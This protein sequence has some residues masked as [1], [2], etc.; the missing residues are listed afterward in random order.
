MGSKQILLNY[1]KPAA[2]A[3]NYRPAVHAFANAIIKYYTGTDGIFGQQ[4]LIT[5]RNRSKGQSH[6]YWIGTDGEGLSQVSKGSGINIMP[7]VGPGGTPL[8]VG[9]GNG[10]PSL[11]AGGSVVVPDDAISRPDYCPGNGRVAVSLATDENPEI[12]T[13]NA[14]GSGRTRLTSNSYIDTSPSWS[15]DCSKIA[16][17]SNRGGGPQIYVMS[18]GGGGA[19]PR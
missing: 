14:D 17:V 5:R 10:G 12:Y 15:P 9:Y 11:M 19:S 16:F 8:Y 4:M 1:A 18:A 13:M 3:S 6:I 2:S 7:G